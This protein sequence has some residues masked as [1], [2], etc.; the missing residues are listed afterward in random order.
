MVLSKKIKRTIFEN[1]SPFI[2]SLVL[3]VISCMLYIMLNM[4]A[5]NMSESVNSFE[6]DCVQEDASFVTLSDIGNITELENMFDAKIEQGASFD[7]NLTEDKTVRVFR[8]NDKV[9]L[10]AV[11]QGSAAGFGEVMLDPAFANA[12]GYKIGDTFKIGDKEYKITGFFS[13]PDYIYIIKSQS[14]LLSDANSFGIAM[15]CKNDFDAYGSVKTFYS[16][17]FNS[18]S[19]SVQTQAR[20]FRDELEKQGVTVM[21]WTDTANNNRVTIV[22]AKMEGIGKVSTLLPVVVLLLTC[23]LTGIVIL[24]MIKQDS[25]I[26]GTLYAQGYRKKEI[27]GHYIRYPLIIAIFGGVI[28][29]VLGALTVK[30]MTAFMLEYFNIPISESVITPIHIIISLLLP[31][32]FLSASA[33]YILIKELR[34]SPVSLMRGGSGSGKVNVIERKI[35][36]D[37]LKFKVKFKLRE[38]FR[39]MSRLVFLLFG[40][41]LATMLLLLGFTAKSSMDYLVGENL[42]NTL[43]FK[44]EYIYN[45]I[46]FDNPPAGTEAFSGGEFTMK[47]DGGDITFTLSG[48]EPDT[49]MIILKDKDGG[50]LDTDKTIITLPLADKLNVKEGDSIEIISKVNSK[51]YTVTVDKIADSY[52]G[53]YVFMPIDEFNDLV[54][55][56]QGSYIGLWSKQ[57]LNIDEKYL[58]SASS[59]DDTINSFKASMQPLQSA[60]GIIGLLSFVI[61]LVVIHVVISLIIEE[62][63]QTISLMKVFGYRKKEINSLILNSPFIII[64][65]GYI[66]G[67]PLIINLMDSAFKSMTQ[68]ID[69][70]FPIVIDNIYLAAGFVFIYLMYELSK[71]LNKR[72]LNKIT[73]SEALKSGKE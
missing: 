40:V 73:M 29:T 35:K 60:L 64:V 45:S 4:L 49:Q 50:V 48:I 9:N 17:K 13:L 34:R 21:Q 14:D 1:K 56:P 65:L 33:L 26:I 68:S 51:A 44:Y 47:K 20:A 42:T 31:V 24:R 43:L 37:R 72:K 10:P 58:Y 55:Y 59:V 18:D 62:N 6:S 15:L 7:Y 3:I 70:A 63:R 22:T 30:P 61:G 8:E 2:G 66:I 41:I 19:Q 54:G 28:G 5:A 16:I 12:N 57:E 52:I 46:H 69:I 67:I 23:I 36:L 71:A 25:V 53:E 11:I 32:V 27:I 38:Q 39:S